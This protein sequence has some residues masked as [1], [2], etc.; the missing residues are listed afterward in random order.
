MMHLMIEILGTLRS[1][2]RELHIPEVFCITNE[3][4]HFRRYAT[5]QG[6]HHPGNADRGYPGV[7]FVGVINCQWSHSLCRK[8]PPG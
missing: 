3:G 6:R 4:S 5:N 1:C 8:L 7:N 2:A